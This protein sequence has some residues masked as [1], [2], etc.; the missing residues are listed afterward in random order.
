MW[1]RAG[2]YAVS[3]IQ[4]LQNKSVDY[5]WYL[6]LMNNKFKY[7]FYNIWIHYKDIVNYVY[8]QMVYVRILCCYLS[9]ILVVCKNSWLHKGSQIRPWYSFDSRRECTWQVHNVYV[10][11]RVCACGY[12]W[13]STWLLYSACTRVSLFTNVLSTYSVGYYVEP[14][15]FETKDPKNRMMQE[16]CA[17]LAM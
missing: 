11:V 6:M 16:V 4:S 8:V 3:T 13:W 9:C 7:L 2:M 12:T 17:L 14:T 1:C 15:I 5:K 10:C